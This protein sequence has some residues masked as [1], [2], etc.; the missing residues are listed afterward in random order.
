MTKLTA[1]LD[2]D[3]VKY[4]AS[5]AGEKR[6]IKA[7][8][9]KTGDEFEF[10][11]RTEMYGRKKSKDGGWLEEFNQKN[12]KNWLYTDFTIVDIQT[13]EPIENVLHTA[14]SMVESALSYLDTTKYKAFVGKG[15][16]FRVQR[17]TLLKYKGNRT[18]L[19]KPL[20]LD[21]V[22]NYL[23]K[24]YN[25]EIVTGI[26][27]DDRVVMEA[28]K[29]KNHVVVGSDKDF[30][31][32][33]VRFFNVNR[34]SEGIVNGD[35]FGKLWRDDNGDVRGIGR[36]FLYYQTCSK[37][38]S[39]NYSANC[40]SDLN[41]GSVSAYNTLCDST[42]DKEAWL[43]IEGVFKKLYPE[44]KTVTGWRGDEILI[45]WK[46]VMNECFDMARMHRFK[47]DFVIAEKVLEK[48]KTT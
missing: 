39:D 27:N 15:E 28:Y 34:H 23:I 44:A 37:D 42:N 1:I 6:S 36:M 22:A 25:A 18:D 13:P 31:G 14:K 47:N 10:S 8:H 5:S 26:E 40:F 11:T 24:K 2:L 7:V 19:I 17:S 41:W 12:N 30:Y 4:T 35:C 32:C 48:M 33:P 21:E 46:Y 43:N 16:S 9:N 38:T 29:Q 45:D 20:Y 3:W